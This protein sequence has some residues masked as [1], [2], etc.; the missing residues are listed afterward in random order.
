MSKKQKNICSRPKALKHW[1]PPNPKI[2][3]L[4]AT[5]FQKSNLVWVPNPPGEPDPWFRFQK[6]MV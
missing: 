6:T 1:T 5:F 3:E 4:E 2:M